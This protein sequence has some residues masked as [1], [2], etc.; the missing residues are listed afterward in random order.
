MLGRRHVPEEPRPGEFTMHHSVETMGAH[1]RAARLVDRAIR[2]ALGLGY[3][4]DRDE[5]P[6]YRMMVSTSAAAPLRA[7]RINGRVP[8]LALRAILAIANRKR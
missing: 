2:F 1:S 8:E 6:E 7:L 4:R 3:G 5:R